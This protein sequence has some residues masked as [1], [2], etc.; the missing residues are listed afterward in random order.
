MIR[1]VRKH[2]AGPAPREA[3]DPTRPARTADD[4]LAEMRLIVER[5]SNCFWAVPMQEAADLI[6]RLT[7]EPQ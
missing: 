5:H 2:D 1:I 3:S 7:G 6:E 4:L